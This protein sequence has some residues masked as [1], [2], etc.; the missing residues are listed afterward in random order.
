MT[1]PGRISYVDIAK[2]FVLL[3]VIF[4]HTF[5][6]SM[7]QAYYWC[8]FLYLFL[9]KFHGSTL[10]LLSGM[11]YAI[12]AQKN[13][14]LSALSYLKKKSKSILLPW[15]SYSLII[16]IIFFAVAKVPSL[17]GALGGKGVVSPLEYLKLMFYNQNPYSFHLWY[18]NTLFFLSIFTFLIDKFSKDKDTAP[19][20]IL[21]LLIVPFIASTVAKPW[22]LLTKGFVYQ[23]PYFIVGTL[24]N[25][26]SIEKSNRKWMLLGLLSAVLLAVHT[27]FEANYNISSVLKVLIFYGENLLTIMIAFG[28]L[29]A[30][31]TFSKKLSFFEK[32][33]R[34]SMVYYLYH[35]PFCCAFLGA[36]LFDKLHVSAVL[37]V[38]LCMT[39]S[40]I[41]PY[42]ISVIARKTRLCKV[43]EWFGLPS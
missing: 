24:I 14:Q 5:R 26:Q 38:V 9:Y 29:S 34:K 23:L 20:K 21:L 35:Q 11:S 16:Y 19:L 2:G 13:K 40:L 31:Y 12:T 41:V 42:L 36:L 37:V 30:C 7:R 25:R 6:E 8:D 3:L 43:L 15:L 39:V 32:I 17:G 1:K 33:G 27:A 10:F 4:G 28:I 22:H 18:L